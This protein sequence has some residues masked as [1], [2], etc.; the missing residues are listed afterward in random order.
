[1]PAI[2]P[3]RRA[4]IPAETE[5]AAVDAAQAYVLQPGNAGFPRDLFGVIVSELWELEVTTDTAITEWL[6]AAEESDEPAVISLL[7]SKWTQWLL[8]QLDDDEEEED[9]EGAGSGSEDSG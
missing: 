8:E 5:R 9:G 1:M 7:A 4:A 3:A 6:E 2:H